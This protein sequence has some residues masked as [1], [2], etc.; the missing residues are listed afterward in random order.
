LK[1]EKAAAKATAFSFVVWCELLQRQVHRRG[2]A[3][4]S[5]GRFNSEGGLPCYDLLDTCQGAPAAPGVLAPTGS[6]TLSSNGT[7]LATVPLTGNSASYQTVAGHIGAYSMTA[8]NSG[9][10][11]YNASPAITLPY[12]EVQAGTSIEAHTSISTVAPGGSVTL[13]GNVTS[14]SHAAP[15][16]GK[17]S[18]SL[19]GA[20]VGTANLI[21]GEDPV[22]AV[23]I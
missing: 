20:V 10:S 4:A 14:N 18:F 12:S 1:A 11:N 7:T 2:L 17:V 3:D 13:I 8:S 15:P 21:V 6:V 19:N 23:G 22:T 16:T 9:D 5:R